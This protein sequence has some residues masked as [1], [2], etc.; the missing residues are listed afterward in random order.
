MLAIE[1]SGQGID[2]VF[3]PMFLR[4]FAR[5]TEAIAGVTEAWEL[6]WLWFVSLS[7]FTEEELLPNRKALTKARA[8]LSGY[9]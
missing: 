6:D 8:S 3:L 4:C 9:R 7:H 2:P 5:Q 1:D